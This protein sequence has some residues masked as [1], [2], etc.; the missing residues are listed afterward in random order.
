MDRVWM[1]A[2]LK[3]RAIPTVRQPTISYSYNYFEADVHV[4]RHKISSLTCNP[5][6]SSLLLMIESLI[7]DLLNRSTK[8]QL[9]WLYSRIS[10][11]L[12]SE[13]RKQYN[14][15]SV[16]KFSRIRFPSETNPSWIESEFVEGLSLK[17]DSRFSRARDCHQSG[18]LSFPLFFALYLEADT[19]P[20]YPVRPKAR[21]R[22]EHYVDVG[23]STKVS[24]TAGKNIVSCRLRNMRRETAR[25]LDEEERKWQSAA[26]ITLRFLPRCVVRR[27]CSFR[28]AS[29]PRLVGGNIEEVPFLAPSFS[30][31]LVFSSQPSFFLRS[32]LLRGSL[33]CAGCSSRMAKTTQLWDTRGESRELSRATSSNS[34]C[35]LRRR[36]RLLLVRWL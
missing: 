25:G 24:A 21:P 16:R 3:F 11:H 19:V 26:G 29:C 20:G 31:S 14:A 18:V 22:L 6:L 27:C 10:T 33:P 30:L 35:G 8:I 12:L 15:R 36:P 17:A 1:P 2:M 5:Q 28:R 4:S 13:R 23:V 7:I 32:S 34:F 9:C